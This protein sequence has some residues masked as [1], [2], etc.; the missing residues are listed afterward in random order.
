[1]GARTIQGESRNRIDCK[2]HRVFFPQSRGRAEVRYR[3]KGP[4]WTEGYR[5]AGE[6]RCEGSRSWM[7]SNVLLPQD[8]WTYPDFEGS[9]FS[10]ALISSPCSQLVL[11]RGCAAW[12]PAPSKYG[13][14]N[15]G[16]LLELYIASEIRWI[17]QD[18]VRERE[19]ISSSDE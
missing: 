5:D 18:P 15:L 6:S 11:G 1:M 16:Q 13:V 12:G 7:S 9:I 14:Q 2:D 8:A 19:R 17:Y 10:S 3:L 4:P